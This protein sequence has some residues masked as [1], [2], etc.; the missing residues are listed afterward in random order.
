MKK[1]GKRM[2]AA[3][4]TFVLFFAMVPE[5]VCVKNVRAAENPQEYLDGNPLLPKYVEKVFD[6]LSNK[7]NYVRPSAKQILSD[8]EKSSQRQKHPRIMITK[9]IVDD[10]LKPIASNT[11]DP[12]NALYN[13]IMA[14][15]ENLC[16]W[17]VDQNSQDQLPKYSYKYESRMPVNGDPEKPSGGNT[18]DDFKYKIM[19]LGFAYQMTDVAAQKKRYAEAAWKILE[20]ITNTYESDVDSNDNFKDVNPWHNL[21]FGTFSQGLAIGYDWFYDAWD[22]EQK[23]RLQNAIVRLCFQVANESYAKKSIFKEV[24]HNLQ[25]SKLGTGNMKGVEYVHNHNS[26]VNSGVIMAALALI[27]EYPET[28]ST[29]CQDAFR[30]MEKNLNEYHP[31]GLSNESPQYWLFSMDNFSMIFSTLETALEIGGD[32]DGL[33][34]L[35]VCPA[36]NGGRTMI[37]MHALESDVGTFTFG[38]TEEGRVTTPGELYYYKHY[39]LHGYNQSIFNR[40]SAKND[41]YAALVEALLWCKVEA[42]DLSGLSL[43]WGPGKD[44]STQGASE[45]ASFRNTFG[46]KQSFVGIKAGTTIRDLFV[47]LDQGSFVFHAQGVKWAVDMGKDKYTL[48]GYTDKDTNGRWKIFRLRPDGHNTL[49]INPNR[50]DF[51]YELGKQAL[52]STECSDSHAKAVVDVTNLVSSK[53]SKARRGFLLTDDRKNLVV[54]DEVTLTKAA[55]VYWVMYTPITNTVSRE[56]NTVTLTATGGEKLTLDFLSNQAGEFIDS[57][58]GVA[59]SAAPWDLAPV[60]SGQNSNSDKKTGYKRIA[61]KVPSA[62]G[63]LSITVKMTRGDVDK[64]SVPGVEEYSEIDTWDVNGSVTIPKTEELEGNVTKAGK[65]TVGEVLSVSVS[66]CNCPEKD[67]TYVWQTGLNTNGFYGPNYVVRQEDVGQ[68]LTCRITDKTG[69]YV[70]QLTARY[71]KAQA[72]EATYDGNL[73]ITKKALQLQ[74]T[75][76]I[77]FK[78]PASALSSYHDPYLAVVQGGSR[79]TLTEYR[80]AGDFYVFTYRVA[81]QTID[82]DVI[83]APHA[84]NADG[85]DVRGEAFIYSVSKYCYNMLGKSEYQ[86]SQYATFRR[87]LVDILRYGDAA[88]VYADY[89]PALLASRNLTSAQNAMGTD[90]SAT[91]KYNSVKNENYGTVNSSEALAKIEKAALYLEAAVN[92]QFKFSANNPSDLRVVITDNAECTNVIAEYPA[93][94]KLTDGSLYYVNVDALNAGE[95]RKTIYATVMKSNKKV[96]NTYR[97]S[98]ESYVS[99]MRTDGSTKLDKLLDAMMRYGDSAAAYAKQN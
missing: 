37:A 58:D 87:L 44:Q 21:D 59:Y 79:E 53:A 51:G 72:P 13:K 47:H 95:M 30:S 23:E 55:D 19:V 24:K 38:D 28:A 25:K 80:K 26:F 22:A 17:I 57:T 33:Y 50:D 60:V 18:S 29:L 91:M 77:D 74:D 64:N 70:G 75:I 46:S 8:Y 34:G 41:D 90:V 99:S 32:S 98:I 69:K 11:N 10:Q 56:G 78:V 84:L 92:V 12:R 45:F 43:D 65:L 76:A 68:Y 5:T 36:L 16:V 49:L 85:K 9:K 6:G 82:E 89:K 81:P 52:L 20:R 14:R 97:Y 48:T 39:D 73:A 94:A 61:Y 96:S 7:G 2:M 42:D 71:N 83:A 27:D 66:N 4:L 62:S 93:N 40:V 1:I 15:A 88:Q 31:S 63:D 3:M 54:R 67:L 35:D 86:G